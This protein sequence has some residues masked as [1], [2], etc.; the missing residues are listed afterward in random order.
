MN[1][2]MDEAVLKAFPLVPAS[3]AGRQPPASGFGTRYLVGR[4]GVYREITLPWIHVRQ[5]IARSALPLPYGA[6]ADV[7]EFRCGPIP[8]GVVRE[9]VADA[10]QAL[11]LEVAGVF[12]WSEAD[13]GWRYARRDAIFASSAHVEYTEVRLNEGEHIVVDVHSHGLHPAFFSGEDDADD[14]GAMKVSLVLGNLDKDRP[15]SKMR[16]CMAGIVQSAHLGG[17]G[18][19]GVLA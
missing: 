3:T 17:D 12:L 9:F 18:R 6:V 15:T 2:M 5:L 8:I 16:L 11:P 19:I 4:D 14:A 7:V 10:R 13:D 1:N